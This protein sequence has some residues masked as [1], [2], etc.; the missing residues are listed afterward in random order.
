M[1]TSCLMHP[2]RPFSMLALGHT[3]L[4]YRQFNPFNPFNMKQKM[5]HQFSNDGLMLEKIGM[6]RQFP[7][8]L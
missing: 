1:L 7:A 4:L 3:K 6:S 2:S 5:L 8:V